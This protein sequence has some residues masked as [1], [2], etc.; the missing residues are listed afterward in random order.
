ME[1]QLYLVEPGLQ[2][3]LALGLPCPGKPYAVS[4]SCGARLAHL[5]ISKEAEIEPLFRELALFTAGA[6]RARAGNGVASGAV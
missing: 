6:L 3:H 4:I 1:Q 2:R 5:A